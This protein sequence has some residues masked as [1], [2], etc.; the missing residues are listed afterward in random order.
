MMPSKH[1]NIKRYLIN[2]EKESVP[3]MFC[4]TKKLVRKVDIIFMLW[5]IKDM[6]SYHNE[7]CFSERP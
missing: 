3:F 5:Y 2:V 1:P 4:R 6:F 7:E